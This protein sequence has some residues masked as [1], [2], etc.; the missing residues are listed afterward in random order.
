MLESNGVEWVHFG[1][2]SQRLYTGNGDGSVHIWFPEPLEGR[3]DHQL[4]RGH[5]KKVSAMVMPVDGS[6][7]LTGSYDGTARVWPMT[8]PRM[9][10]L[11]CYAAGRSPTEQEWQGWLPGQPYKPICG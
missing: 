1:P 10:Q 8:P 9:I 5:E 3:D 7:L 6:F 4:L 11:G 2:D